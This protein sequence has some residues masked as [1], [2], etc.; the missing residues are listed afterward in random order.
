MDSD[1][2][3]LFPNTN[4]ISYQAVIVVPTYVRKVK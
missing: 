1:E 3:A 4:P 2:I